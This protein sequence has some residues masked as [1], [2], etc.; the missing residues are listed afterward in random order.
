MDAK[1]DNKTTIFEI[2]VSLAASIYFFFVLLWFTPDSVLRRN[3]FAPIYKIW[4]FCGL[5]QSWS[6]FSPTIRQLNYYPSAII[7]FEDGSKTLW[8]PPLMDRLSL[9]ERFQREKFRKWSIDSLP[10]PRFKDFWV[11]FARF[12]GRQ[13]YNPVNKPVAVSL[14]LRWIEIPNPS[15]KFYRQNEL[16]PC[17]K[18]NT[19]F[20]YLFTKEDF[21]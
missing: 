21:Q 9:I 1:T 20:C 13:Y 2:T 11:D 3:L 14:N 12:V 8:E 18:F 17:T 7:T 19:S 15:E 16:P 6:L 10:W 4:M 5:N